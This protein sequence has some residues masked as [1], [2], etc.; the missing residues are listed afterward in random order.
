VTARLRA[1]LT[2]AVVA[3]A[4]VG[5]TTAFAA[6]G[7]QAT[8]EACSDSKGNVKLAAA[9]PC[10]KGFTSVGQLYTKAGADAAFLTKATADQTYLGKNDSA[11]NAALLGGYPSDAFMRAGACVGYP[12]RGIDWRRCDL[13][14]AN[15]AEANLSYADLREAQFVSA[16][17]T[18]AK[19][20][21]SDLR[22]A[23]LNGAN[24]LGADLSS[25]NLTTADLT[26]A[27]LFMA[28]M[29]TADRGAVRWGS[30]TKCPD[31]TF[32]D[33]NGFTCEGHIIQ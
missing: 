3:V 22:G 33:E 27:N 16:D 24:L 8:V 13:A 17:L 11:V 25:A 14:F 6:I 29:Y 26:G 9:L 23:H 19:L 7:D 31:G 30:G 15:L 32:S 21:S 2:L 12:H 4:V 28:R 1:L 5:A 18:L 10:P 20:N